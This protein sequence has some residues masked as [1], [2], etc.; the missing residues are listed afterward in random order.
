LYGVGYL[1]L[2]I[3]HLYSYYNLLHINIAIYM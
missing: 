2:V 1:K 3:L